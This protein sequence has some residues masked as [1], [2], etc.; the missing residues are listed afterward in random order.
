MCSTSAA[1]MSAT[2]TY[3]PCLANTQARG[4][5]MRPPP[6]TVI[7]IWVFLALLCNSSLVLLRRYARAA[8]CPPPQPIRRG[9]LCRAAKDTADEAAVANDYEGFIASRPKGPA[10]QANRHHPGMLPLGGR[11]ES[12]EVARSGVVARNVRI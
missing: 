10:R 3:A 9:E 2:V 5:P 8:W 12:T 7:L 1:L 11:S 4:R 6:T